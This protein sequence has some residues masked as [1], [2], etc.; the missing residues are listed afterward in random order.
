MD[1]LPL[2]ARPSLDHYRKRA[3][4][5]VAA[6]RSSDPAAVRAWA[7][8]WLRALATSLDA[9]PTQFV[10]HS[11]ERAAA[12]I[13]RRVRANK[14]FALSDAQFLI[15]EAH[16]F[17]NWARF[18]DHVRRQAPNDTPFEAAA[19]AVVHGE[20]EVLQ[21][22]IA[23]HPELIRAHSERVH[24]ATLLHY[25]AANGVEDFRQRTPPNAVAI[26]RFLLE[27]GAEV[28]ALASTYGDDRYQTTMN[29]LV[30]SVHPADAG[31]QP[32][33]VDTLIDF[34]AAVEGL[35]DDSSPLMTAL[36]FGYGDAA[37]TLVRRGARVDNIIAAAS[38]GRPDLVEQLMVDGRTLASGARLVSPVWF[39]I[40]PDQ[41]VYIELAFVWAC[42]F[43]RAE[44]AHLMLDRGVNPMAKDNHDMTAL[45]W[46]GASGIASVVDR[47][48]SLGVPLEARNTWG[49]TVLTSTLHFAFFIPYRGVDYVPI[50]ERLVKAGADVGQVDPFPTGNAGIDAVLAPYRR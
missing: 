7:T 50:I 20:L 9:K 39:R 42:K 40:A 45:H 16:G 2:P 1:T 48:L 13:E 47:L 27:R 21:Q 25:V 8:D 49:G 31:L 19:D 26:A 15:A 17:D 35:D 32:Q 38:M 34:G 23:E 33:R 18:A 41:Q 37:D 30:S 10:Q 6:A 29:L 4:E 14:E 43:G 5:L 46:A 36:A 11:M 44:V 28:D 24:R 22:L 12:H 3:K